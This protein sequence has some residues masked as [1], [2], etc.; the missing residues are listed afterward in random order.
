M[1]SHHSDKDKD[2]ATHVEVGEAKFYKVDSL[3]YVEEKGGNGAGASY[4]IATGAPIEIFNPL[5]YNV[6]FWTALMM[7]V[8]QTIGTGIFSTPSNV[9]RPQQPKP[10]TSDL[11]WYRVC[12]SFP[13]LLGYW[14]PRHP[15][16][17]VG[18]PRARVLLPLP[19]RR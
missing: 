17:R 16:R 11:E 13:Y 18:V 12:R 14:S 19:V 4:Q 8:G 9:R 5:G 6:G 2:S 1:S 10:L 7:N 3:D 15:R